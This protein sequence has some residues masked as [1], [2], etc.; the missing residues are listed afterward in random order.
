MPAPLGGVMHGFSPL[1]AIA[2]HRPGK[3]TPILGGTRSI[4]GVGWLDAGHERGQG[5]SIACRVAA[6]DQV[7]RGSI[8]LEPFLNDAVSEKN[9]TMRMIFEAYFQPNLIP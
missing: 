8:A 2:Q 5:P 4:G 7:R 9:G 1:G 3:L 6:E